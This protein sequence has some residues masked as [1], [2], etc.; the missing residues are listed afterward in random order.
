MYSP[1]T[2]IWSSLI[3]G[4]SA[5]TL[6][7][8][9]ESGLITGTDYKFRVRASN[10]FGWGEFSEEV[11]IRADEVPAQI[12]PVTTI[13]ESIYVKTTWSLPSTN[14]GAS[15]SQYKIFFIA[16]DGSELESA[17]CDGT[18]SDIVGSA[19]PSCKVLIT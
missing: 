8:H 6:I 17:D 13:S 5:Y 1:L 19:T 7:T 10:L 2:E 14:N 11:T 9:V 16:A 4:T 18:D 3:G 15:I 12:T